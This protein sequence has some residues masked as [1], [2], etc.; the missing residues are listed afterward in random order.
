MKISLLL[1][2]IVLMVPVLPG[3]GSTKQTIALTVGLSDERSVPNMPENI[4]DDLNYNRNVVKISI[5]KD[6]KIIRFEPI[7][8]GT[9]NFILRDDKGK[10]IV[11]YSIV[12]RKSN[13][14]KVA[15]EIKSLL[16]DIEG[17]DIK[18]VN[19]KVVIDGEILLPKDMSRIYNVVA[20]FSD[21]ASSIVTM[22]PLAQKKISELIEKDIGNPEIHVRAVNEKF[23]LEGVA[24]NEN[25]K[26]KA[27]IIA[28]TYVPDVVIDAAE[29]AGIVKKRK[30]DSVINLLTVKPGPE[31]QPGKTIKLVI[32]YVELQKDYTKAFRF[33]WTPSLAGDATQIQF[34][35]GDSGS[36]ASGV[37]SSITG[38]VNNLLPKLNW[39]KSHGHARILKSSSIIVQDGNPGIINSGSKEP[40]TVQSPYGQITTQFVD[41]GL[42]SKITPNIIN[43]KSDSVSLVVEFSL[44]TLVSQSAKGPETSMNEIQTKVTVRSGQSAAIGGLV[45]NSSGMAYNRLPAGVDNPII[46]LYASKQFQQ[47][48]SQFVVFITPIIMNSASEGSEQIKKKFRLKE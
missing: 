48:Q 1:L 3:F 45:G 30:I 39:A 31:A 21:V 47:N 20:Q 13:L 4:G 19:N 9:T 11:E 46:S 28:K 10:K 25:E 36:G 37:M 7:T 12:V 42:K 29:S 17:I 32:H 35:N 26:T 34:S 41:T 43:Q 22:S 23:I 44:T 6:L 24:G 14:N 5:A 8:V 40:Y 38:T 33:Q 16:G 27:E 2:L 18:I 15:G